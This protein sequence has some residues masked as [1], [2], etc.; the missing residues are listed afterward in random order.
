MVQETYLKALENWD[1]LEDWISSRSWLF[2]IL[3]HLHVDRYRRS[4]KGPVLVEFSDLEKLPE[5]AAEDGV[6]ATIFQGV[7]DQ[8]V[9]RALEL[10]PLQYREA[11]VLCDLNGLSYAETARVLGVPQG[12]VKSR[13]YRGRRVLK[14]ALYQYAAARRFVSRHAAESMLSAG[15][16]SE[17]PLRAG[18]R[19]GA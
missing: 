14:R 9:N 11:V 18:M 6:T 15:S 19:A 10:L 4:Q 16:S 12:T 2:S 5:P 13:V 7:L 8:E 17:R 1:R 3:R